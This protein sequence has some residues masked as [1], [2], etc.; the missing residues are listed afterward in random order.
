MLKSKFFF[1]K[2]PIYSLLP[3]FPADIYVSMEGINIRNS[4]HYFVEYNNHC[5]TFLILIFVNKRIVFKN[6]MVIFLNWILN[7]L[8]CLLKGKKYLKTILL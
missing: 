2:E 1:I 5:V 4:L 6:I 8:E 3:S 7:F